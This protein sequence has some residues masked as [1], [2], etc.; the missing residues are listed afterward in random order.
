M[1]ALTLPALA[2]LAIGATEL[3]SV[4]G[5]RGLLQDAADAA[6][7]E[8]VGELKIAGT[9]GLAERAEANALNSLSGLAGQSTVT[10]HATVDTAS[11]KVEVA[12]NRL[13][14][15]GNMLPPGG[16]D[17]HVD[18]TAVLTGGGTPLCV[19]NLYEGNS[20]NLYLKDSSS[21]T[22]LGCAVHSNSD[23]LVDRYASLTSERNQAVRSAKG[24]ITPAAIVPA[25]LM[26]DP[27]ADRD[28]PTATCRGI[29]PAI[30]YETDTYVA[31]GTHC[32]GIIVGK[33]ATVTFGPGVHYFGVGALATGDLKLRDAA[34]IKGQDVVLVFGQ[35]TTLKAQNYATIDLTGRRSG[36]MAGMVLVATR[37]NT[38][39][40][41]ISSSNA[42]RIEGVIYLPST[43]LTATGDVQIAQDSDWTVTVAQGVG[44]M[45]G[46]RLKINKRYL[47]SSVPVPSY[48]QGGYGEVRLLN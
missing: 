32:G 26:T 21:L 33:T 19:L 5:E 8:A 12:S 48:V 14:F 31:A 25:P 1:T 39:W 9:Q 37:D 20:A 16:F 15:F 46:A 34:T 42:K 41:D 38:K 24:K 18:A 43:A 35:D 44:L 2:V 27:L 40:M 13:S 17:I 6:A 22:A 30:T 23:I 28:I 29:E 11:V 7:L 3:V 4:N 36:A 10:A 47:E 45:R